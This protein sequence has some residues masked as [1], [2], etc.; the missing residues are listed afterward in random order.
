M[1]M[2][3]QM[4]SFFAGGFLA[5]VLFGSAMA[6]PL[7][8]AKKAADRGDYAVEWR[9]LPPLANQGD[10]NAQAALGAL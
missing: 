10:A 1:S 5:L 9:L 6:G 7:E 3:Q 4:D 8:D 2:K